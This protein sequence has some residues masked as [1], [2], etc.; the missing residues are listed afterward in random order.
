[1]GN[2]DGVRATEDLNCGLLS[3]EPLCEF[4]TLFNPNA[5]IT[6]A[7]NHEAGAPRCRLTQDS[8]SDLAEGLSHGAVDRM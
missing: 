5:L 7:M 1:M 6:C 4:L 8:L 3:S 2:I